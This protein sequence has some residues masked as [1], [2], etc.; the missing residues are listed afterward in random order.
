MRQGAWTRWPTEVP[1]NPDH[2]VILKWWNWCW[3]HKVWKMV[4]SVTDRCIRRSSLCGH[5]DSDLSTARTMWSN[6]RSGMCW[7]FVLVRFL[8]KVI[9][10]NKSSSRSRNIWSLPNEL[11]W[12]RHRS[13][14]N[15]YIA[16]LCN[17][18][19]KGMQ[20]CCVISKGV[21]KMQERL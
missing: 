11:T 3:F 10:I 13:C 17:H 5:S 6:Y 18:F 15:S 7:F 12:A 2:S 20:D 19:D 1:S 16:V 14:V 21:F 9:N 8:E 4:S